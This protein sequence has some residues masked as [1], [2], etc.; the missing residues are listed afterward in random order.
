MVDGTWLARPLLRMRV[1]ST[2]LRASREL[3]DVAADDL[4]CDVV[5]IASR[6][7]QPTEEVRK[8]NRVSALGVDR[9]IA[10]GQFP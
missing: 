10:Q 8:A 9:T 2:L 5:G 1:D 3:G 6:S 4:T 7:A